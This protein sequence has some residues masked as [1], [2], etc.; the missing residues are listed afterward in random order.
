MLMIPEIHDK[1]LETS[2][3][4]PLRKIKAELHGQDDTYHAILADECKDLSVN[5]LIAICMRDLH[6]GAI[7]EKAVGFVSTH[8]LT[9]GGISS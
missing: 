3:S 2:A 7:K 8:N 1:L 4:L 9:S 5:E 6:N